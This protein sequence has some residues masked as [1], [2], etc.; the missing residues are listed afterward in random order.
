MGELWGSAQDKVGYLQL[1]LQREVGNGEDQK[2]VLV[3]EGGIYIS[4]LLKTT[5][6]TINVLKEGRITKSKKMPKIGICS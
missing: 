3:V 5:S 1:F 2:I 4:V 6:T